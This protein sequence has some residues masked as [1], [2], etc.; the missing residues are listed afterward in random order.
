MPDWI[1]SA[2]DLLWRNGLAVLPLVVIVAGV[3]K[4]VPC[5]PSTKHLL[6]VMVLVWLVMPPPVPGVNI[7]AGAVSEAD[8]EP[9][10]KVG[11]AANAALA[12]V[13]AVTIVPPTDATPDPGVYAPHDPSGAVHV[14]PLVAD[15]IAITDS[16]TR[17]FQPEPPAMGSSLPSSSLPSERGRAVRLATRHRSRPL[18]R[19]VE[20]TPKTLARA[21]VPDGRWRRAGRGASS[22]RAAGADA[23]RD[24]FPDRPAQRRLTPI[25]SRPVVPVT[26]PDSDALERSIALALPA[27]G[28][29]PPDAVAG[30]QTGGSPTDIGAPVRFD[31]IGWEAGGD[32]AP[33]WRAWVASMVDVRDAVARIPVIPS[34]LWIGGV[35]ALGLIG[36]MRVIAF[37]SRVR[38]ATPADRSVRRLVQRAAARMQIRRLPTVLMVEDRV[39]PMISCGPCPRLILPRTLWDEL[40]DAGR[41]AVVFHELAHL[42][43]RDHLVAWADTFVGLL[44]WWHP[45]VWWVRGRLHAEAEHCCDAWVTTLRPKERRVYAQTLLRTRAYLSQEPRVLPAMTIGMTSGRAKRFARRLTMVMTNRVKPGLSAPGV[46]LVLSVAVMGWLASPVQSCP[47]EKSSGK[48]KLIKSPSTF[49]AHL[50]AK[51]EQNQANQGVAQVRLV[52]DDGDDD[53]DKRLERLEERLEMLMRKLEQRDEQRDEQREVQRDRQLRRDREREVDRAQRRDDGRG[54]DDGHDDDDGRGG[55]G[56]GRDG[57]HPSHGLHAHGHAAPHPPKAPKALKAP[58][59]PRGPKGPRGLFTPNAPVAPRASEADRGEKSWREYKLS[60]KKLEKF[61]GLMVLD[62][63]PIL[64]RP[65]D[66]SIEI[67]ATEY[68]HGIFN[69]FF[70]MIDPSPER[71]G[72]NFIPGPAWVHGVGGG[73]AGLGQPGCPGCCQF[74]AGRRGCGDNCTGC[75]R[76]RQSSKVRAMATELRERARRELTRVRRELGGKAAE[77]R[78]NAREEARRIRER[79]REQIR[80][81]RVHADSHGELLESLREQVDALRDQGEA[82][83]NQADDLRDR[84][85]ELREKAAEDSVGAQARE[86]FEK[87]VQGLVA[88]AEELDH[89][90]ESMDDLAGMLEGETPVVEDQVRELEDYV[91]ELAERESAIDEARQLVEDGVEGNVK[92]AETMAQITGSLGSGCCDL[93]PF[94]TGSVP[95]FVTGPRDPFVPVVAWET[96]EPTYEVIAVPAP[97]APDPNVTYTPAVPP[98]SLTGESANAQVATDV[99]KALEAS[100]AAVEAAMVAE[101]KASPASDPD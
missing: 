2:T 17:A 51:N 61:T 23:P 26:I 70:Q 71:A 83:R 40:D 88:G 58:K 27:P 101:T 21:S 49:E 9:G 78:E 63:V 69:A 64:V 53:L 86:S 73:D 67:Q 3:T 47:N 52:N 12:P 20:R 76:L 93:S 19:S 44:Y 42:R 59:A 6:W 16:A 46:A 39:S 75:E 92:L 85:E 62:D 50:A 56:F 48:E 98:V 60:G 7:N 30:S 37:S 84:A 57:A 28:E 65:G 8:V 91:S 31:A 89:N 34:S 66:D 79:V 72:A 94:P 15:S 35:G 43:R 68:Q 5:R 13:A 87:H 77:L 24:F 14:R 32:D 18:A 74:S 80:D 41:E 95:R 54:R 99:A 55:R 90:A 4:F 100:L 45:L 29:M 96:P 11:G 22:R 1:I 25:W 38:A 97:A 33:A 10:I 36:L 82:L 81:V